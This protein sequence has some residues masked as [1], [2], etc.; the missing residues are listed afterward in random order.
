VPLDDL[1]DKL[2]RLKKALPPGVMS[3]SELLRREPVVHELPDLSRFIPGEVRSIGDETCFVSEEWFPF[4]GHL[5]DYPLENLKNIGSEELIATFGLEPGLEGGRVLFIDTETTGLAGGTGTYAFLVGVGSIEEE[6]FRVVQFFMRDYDEEMG[7]MA[8][9]G[10]ELKRCGLMVTY[11]GA[12]FDLP[13]LKTRFVF[14]RVRVNL[15]DI[16]HLDLLP[17]AR[18][19]WK[20]A[21]GGANLSHLE[22]KVLGNEREG[23][24][25]GSL[26]PTLY[27]HFLRGASPR[28]LAPVF[29]HNRMD[30]LS[31]AAL[32]E[33][34]CRCHACPE[35]IESPWERLGVA[36]FFAT[37]GQ[38]AK[39]AAVLEPVAEQAHLGME[40]HLCARLLAGLLKRQ[41][42]LDRAT[43][44]WWRIC[45]ERGFDPL[46]SIELAK[47]LEHVERDLER[48][49]GL[50]LEIFERYNVEPNSDSEEAGESQDEEDLHYDY[51]EWILTR[52]E[53]VPTLRLDRESAEDREDET[54]IGQPKWTERM[55][56][57]LNHRLQRLN[58]KISRTGEGSRS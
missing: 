22:N 8:L 46:V 35:S 30:I 38:E 1:A 25:P 54:L 3:G 44:L 56:R 42:Q 10:E 17:V 23:D 5:G 36:R 19:L 16:P 50:V 14:N 27:F 28:T 49:R 24:V 41:G 48:A 31:L 58:R 6:G 45:R 2:K 29:Y 18:R 7:Q 40:W 11:N 9:L 12:A 57:E 43:S 26:I 4:D 15:M 53:R 20:P 37:R 39:A 33:R 13:L 32:T 21:H 51:T 34:A 52:Q 47:Y 55:A